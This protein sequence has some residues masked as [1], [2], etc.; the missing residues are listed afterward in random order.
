IG[1]HEQMI[2]NYFIKGKTNGKAEAVN[3]KIQR[4][5]VANYGVRDKDFFMYGLARYFSWHIKILISLVLV[6]K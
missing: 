5:I 3:R 2:M 4:F 1:G 6:F